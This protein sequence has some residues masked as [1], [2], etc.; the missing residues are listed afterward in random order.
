MSSGV[1]CMTHKSTKQK[2]NTKS[3]KESELVSLD[4]CM[5]QVLWTSIFLEAQCYG[6]Q[7]LV[8]YQDNRSAMLL[9]KMTD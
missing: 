4:D 1:G 6:G 2:I 3:S 9:E 8:I 5:T 7:H